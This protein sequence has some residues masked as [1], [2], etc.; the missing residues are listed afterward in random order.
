P[1]TLLPPPELMRAITVI[2]ATSARTPNAIQA[3]LLIVIGFSF[4]SRSFIS[5]TN[6]IL[7]GIGRSPVS[8]GQDQSF[9]L[10]EFASSR[11]ADRG[12][13]RDGRSAACPR[14]RRPRSRC[15]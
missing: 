12:S 13:R 14:P 2:A 6:V 11:Q 4:Q 10:L 8:S 15:R 5:T 1:P 7:F 3:F 9:A